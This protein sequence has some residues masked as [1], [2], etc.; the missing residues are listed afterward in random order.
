[1]K[2]D[3]LAAFNT[4]SRRLIRIWR[5]W[6]LVGSKN[7]KHGAERVVAGVRKIY[8]NMKLRNKLENGLG[9][10]GGAP[11][12]CKMISAIVG[13]FLNGFWPMIHGKNYEKHYFS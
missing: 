4:N 10:V 12:W 7:R 8:K 3:I 1:M 2:L 13:T 6:G 5:S 11:D 9:L